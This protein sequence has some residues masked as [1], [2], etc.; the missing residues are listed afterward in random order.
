M[1][2]GLLATIVIVLGGFIYYALHS[3][4]F[5]LKWAL[6]TFYIAFCIERTWENFFT[7]RETDRLQ[8]KDDWSL[9]AVSVVFAICMAFSMAEFLF[10]A[11][12]VDAF[13]TCAGFMFYFCSVALRF[14]SIKSLGDQWGIHVIGNN[15]LGSKRRRLTNLGPYRIIRHPIYLGSIIEAIAV[16]LILN[17]FASICIV[18]GIF[19]PLEMYRARLEERT[20]LNDLGHTYLD[21]MSRVPGFFPWFRDH[22]SLCF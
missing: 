15:K 21:Y 19:V 3:P 14:W 11:R 10:R 16:P 22:S 6:F 12:Q 1:I 9:V 2:K 17:S 18:M 5:P 8:V 4:F 7:S 20:L 13:L